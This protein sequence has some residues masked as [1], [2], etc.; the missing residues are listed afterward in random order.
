MKYIIR[1]REAGNKID[2]VATMEEAEKMI[3]E[4]EAEDKADGTYTEDFYEI[5]MECCICGEVFTGF[6]NNPYPVVKDEDARCCD[7]CNAMY[8]IPR[9]ILD[10]YDKK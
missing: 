5:A 3:E 7:N 8:V 4:F 1:D 9:R 6:G 10:F 2:E